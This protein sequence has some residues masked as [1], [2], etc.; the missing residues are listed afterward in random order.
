MKIPDKTEAIEIMKQLAPVYKPEHL[1]VPISEY[2][3]QLAGEMVGNIS[4]FN[5]IDHK[6]KR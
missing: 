4:G 3:E 6:R 1:F 2:K 5:F